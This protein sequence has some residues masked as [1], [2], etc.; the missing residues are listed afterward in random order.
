MS[1]KVLQ[2]VYKIDDWESTEDFIKKVAIK[3]GRVQKMS[4]PNVHAVSVKVLMDW[5]RGVIPHFK[6]P[7]D[8]ETEQK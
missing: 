2:Y 1:K 4:E 6:L 3:L 7:P 8:G 5:Q